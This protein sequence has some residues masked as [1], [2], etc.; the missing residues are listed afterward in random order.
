MTHNLQRSPELEQARALLRTIE[1]PAGAKARVAQAL[2]M[3]QSTSGR[4]SWRWA[5]GLA[6][7]AATST[8]AAAEILPMRS[9]IQS[10]LPRHQNVSPAT[11]ATLTLAKAP[12][13]AT[14]RPVDPTERAEAPAV[15]TAPPPAPQQVA[16][17]NPAPPHPI[18]PITQSAPVGLEQ[19]EPQPPAEPAEAPIELAVMVAEYQRA[20]ALAEHNPEGGIS[21]FRKLQQKWPNGPLRAEIDL[22][23]VALLNRLGKRDESRKQVGEFLQEHPDS[24]RARELGGALEEHR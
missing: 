21:E 7:L 12:P 13:P 2:L 11:D 4:R 17:R 14:P 20:R 10:L 18:R 6:L 22:Q 23:L 19:V 8:A 5:L 9:W 15:D 24:S 1:P 16:N 3:Q